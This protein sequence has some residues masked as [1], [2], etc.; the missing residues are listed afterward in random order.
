MPLLKILLWLRSNWKAVV[1]VGAAVAVLGAG[2]Y[3]RHLRA[4]LQ[5]EKADRVELQAKFDSY[6]R[7]A[8]AMVDALATEREEAVKRLEAARN[9]E[10]EILNVPHEQDG[11]VAPVLRDSLDRLRF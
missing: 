1:A 7:K 6:S 10:R 9:R 11:P 4:E 8:D 5:A 2:A 3:I